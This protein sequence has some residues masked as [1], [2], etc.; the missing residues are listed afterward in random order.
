MNELLP[1]SVTEYV[2]LACV[3]AILILPQF[4][5]TPDTPVVIPEEDNTPVTPVVIPE[6]DNTPVTPVVIPDAEDNHVPV[7]S[8]D[9]AY[10]SHRQIFADVL[11]EM[12]AEGYSKMYLVQA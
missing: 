7:D 10:E 6:E 3:L 11:E 5:N 9:K 8:M 2:I 4:N 1:K 12:V